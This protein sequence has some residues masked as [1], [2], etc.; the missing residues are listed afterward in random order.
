MVHWRTFQGEEYVSTWTDKF[1]RALVSLWIVRML[2]SIS[3]KNRERVKK[4]KE[5]M[6]KTRKMGLFLLAKTKEAYREKR[7]IETAA[8]RD[9]APGVQVYKKRSKG[10]SS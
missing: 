7:F 1:G 9:V 8:R 5:S 6:K 4:K 3:T 10:T 2:H